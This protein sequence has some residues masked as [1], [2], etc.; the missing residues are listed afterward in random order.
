MNR[1]AEAL[2]RASKAR[3]HDLTANFFN[4]VLE[5]KATRENETL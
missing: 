4:F 1:P 5:A 3:G 2:A